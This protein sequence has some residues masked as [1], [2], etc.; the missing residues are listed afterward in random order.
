MQSFNLMI[1]CTPLKPNVLK[2]LE[3]NEEDQ[4]NLDKACLFNRIDFTAYKNNE[5]SVER[6][7]LRYANKMDIENFKK[8]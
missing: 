8:S 1:E 3:S 7:Y 2:F 4:V 6:K 5:L